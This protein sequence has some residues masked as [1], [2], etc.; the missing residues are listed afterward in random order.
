[1]SREDDEFWIFKWIFPIMGV[2]FIALIVYR[3]FLT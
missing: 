1:M 2:I 3:L